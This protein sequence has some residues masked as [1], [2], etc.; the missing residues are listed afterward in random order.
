MNSICTKN[1]SKSAFRA[2]TFVLVILA[3]MRATGSHAQ[4]PVVPA[5]AGA[6]DPNAVVK[7]YQIR[8]GT[9]TELI[10]V[11]RELAS[12]V[13]FVLGPQPKFVR[14]TPAGETLGVEGGVNA[15]PQG[16]IPEANVADQFV[17]FLVLRGLPADVDKAMDILAKIDLPAPQVLIEA[18]LLDCSSGFSSQMG[19]SWD[20][21]PNGTTANF[22]L[23]TPSQKG[24]WDSV[25]FGRLSRSPIQFNATLQ[26]AIQKNTARVL[27]SPNLIAL[28]NHRA[29]IF[30]GDEV[31]Y[32]SGAQ[33]SQSGTTLQTAK[34]KVGVQLNVVAAANGDGTINL[35]INPEVG[36]LLQLTTLANGVALPRLTRRTVTTS[37]RVKNGE[38]LV[39]GGLFSENEVSTLRKV[40]LLGDLPILG[41]LFRQDGKEKSRSELIIMLK[42]T[43]VKD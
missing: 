39:I 14:D 11:A 28:Y 1:R 18:M 27:A 35:K 20:F 23:G 30:I 31:T 2:F 15:P 32:L 9:P 33:A 17:R 41:R 36:S 19:V 16:A 4:Q 43:I 29:Q 34:V 7:T 25:A 26:A 10:G 24:N 3:G 37:V 6:L 40:P 22:N 13:Q 38:T 12:N 5:P 8:Y 21:A 42:A